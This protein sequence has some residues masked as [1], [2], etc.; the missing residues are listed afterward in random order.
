MPYFPNFSMCSLYYYIWLKDNSVSLQLYTIIKIEVTHFNFY[1][2]VPTSLI[3]IS[4]FT[5]AENLQVD[6]N[7]ERQ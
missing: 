4:Y 3:L 2:C 1:N 7:M 5:C 6:K